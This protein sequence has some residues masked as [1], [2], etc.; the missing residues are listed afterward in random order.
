ML[1]PHELKQPYHRIELH[2]NIDIACARLISASK[3][4]KHADALHVILAL[5]A[6]FL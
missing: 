2:E 3:R 5:Q 6:G 4:S 1:E